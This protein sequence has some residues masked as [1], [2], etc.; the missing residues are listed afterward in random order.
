[1]FLIALDQTILATA[2]PKITDQFDTVADVGWYGSVTIHFELGRMLQLIPPRL[3][4]LFDKHVYPAHVWEDLQDIQ[5]QC[6]MAS[7][8]L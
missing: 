6:N 8:V 1:M 5:R 4:V 2:I 7:L 3:G